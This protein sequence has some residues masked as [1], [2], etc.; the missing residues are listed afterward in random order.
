MDFEILDFSHSDRDGESA[1]ERSHRGPNFAPGR[2]GKSRNSRS[3]TI[4]RIVVQII[5]V[6]IYIGYIYLQYHPE[7]LDTVFARRYI[8]YKGRQ[9]FHKVAYYAD[10]GQMICKERYDNLTEGSWL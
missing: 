4:A 2:N 8:Y 5:V 3:A 7:K 9:G 10:Y 1:G 6:I